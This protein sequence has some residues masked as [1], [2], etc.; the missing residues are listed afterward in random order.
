MNYQKIKKRTKWF[1][2]LSKKIIMVRSDLIISKSLLE[3]YL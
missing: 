2:P 3:L 1:S